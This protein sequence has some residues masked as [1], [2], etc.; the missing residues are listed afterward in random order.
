M[1]RVVLFKC[2]WADTRDVRGCKKDD[3]GHTM[4]IFSHLIHTGNGEEDEPYVLASQ[5]RLVYYVEDP[6]E[7]GWCVV[8]HVKPRDLYDMGDPNVSE[9]DDIMIEELPVHTVLC[10]NVPNIR[11]VRQLEDTENSQ[12][13]YMNMSGAEDSIAAPPLG[14]ELASGKWRVRVIDADAKITEQQLSG[15]EVWS[16]QNQQIMVDFN[17]KGQPIKDSGGLFGSWLGSLSTDLNILHINYTDWRKVPK[18][19][20]E[21][22]WKV[23]QEEETGREPSRS[24]IFIASRC[25]SDGSFICDEARISV[26][27]LKQ[28]MTEGSIQGEAHDTYEQVFGPENPG[29][30]RCDMA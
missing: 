4:V 27:K 13:S 3:L 28:V 21:M 10:D 18:Y 23:I 29:R 2:Q 20:K 19:R 24:E 15:K 6:K 9:E 5:A 26:E 12:I 1:F 11:L 17:R 7:K 30:V 14:P 16:M 25:R 8:V 22:A